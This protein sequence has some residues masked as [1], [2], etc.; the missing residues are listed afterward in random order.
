MATPQERQFHILRLVVKEII[1]EK[2]I[3]FT[4]NLGREI[5]STVEKLNKR[6]QVSPPL[7]VHE[8]LDLYIPIIR[9]L[10]ETHVE[11]LKDVRDRFRDR[12][13]GEARGDHE[14]RKDA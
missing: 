13:L 3:S 10:T 12:E 1:R 8:I 6:Y 7:Q 4:D 5:S 11:D 14:L 9:E 2:G